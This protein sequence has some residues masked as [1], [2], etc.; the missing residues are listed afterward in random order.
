QSNFLTRAD[1][2]NQPEIRGCEHAKILTILL[3]NALDV[4]CDHQL[5]AGAS[6]RVWRL[7]PAGALPTPLPAHRGNKAALLYV[8]ALDRQLATALQAGV[9]K[10]AQ[11]FVKEEADVCRGNLVG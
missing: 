2:V 6:L 11:S 4:L 8:A 10:L 3:V 5:N 1:L 7:L 9:E